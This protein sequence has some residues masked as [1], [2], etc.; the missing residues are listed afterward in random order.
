MYK[1]KKSRKD[2]RNQGICKDGRVK[3]SG[4]KDGRVKDSGVKDGRVKENHTKYNFVG[5]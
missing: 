3:D 2:G 4:V 1:P 5:A